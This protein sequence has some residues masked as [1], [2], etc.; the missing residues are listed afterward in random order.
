M[1]LRRQAIQCFANQRRHQLLNAFIASPIQNSQKYVDE[2]ANADVRSEAGTMYQNFSKF[3]SFVNWLT[4]VPKS[5][6]DGRFIA[7]KDNICTEDE[8]TTCA[9]K[10]LDGFLSP[11]TATVVKKLIAAG[12]LII[13]KTNLDEFGMGCVSDT[14]V[15]FDKNHLYSA[16]LIP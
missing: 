16:V 7:V 9:S 3:F 13:G 11:N 1:S 12:A 15:L 2:A 4:G 10:I 14:S 6:V 5:N 8:P